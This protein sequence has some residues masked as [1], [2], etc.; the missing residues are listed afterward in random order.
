MKR[1]ALLPAL[2]RLRILVVGDLMLDRYWMGDA[3]RLSPEAPVPVV[4][5]RETR[6]LL[7][8]AGNVALNLAAIGVKQIGLLGVVGRDPA[9]E[10]LRRL[11]EERGIAA[12]L[13]EDASRPTVTKVRIISR[14][15]QVTRVDFEEVF[16]AEASAAVAARYVEV[17]GDYDA[18]IFSDYAKGA[19][20]SI[21]EMLAQPNGPALKLV[22]P[23]A[24]D[25]GRYRGATWITPNWSEFLAAGGR[26]GGES[27]VETSAR[28]LL[29]KAGI[30]RMLLTRG[31]KGVSVLGEDVRADFPADVSKVHDVTGAGDTVIAVFA[32]CLATGMAAAEA[33]QL[34]NRAAG[35]VVGR[36]GAAQVSA[37]EL[38]RLYVG[39]HT[40]D[41]T[42]TLE[43][44]GEIFEAIAAARRAGERIVF[45][46]GCFD[47]LHYGHVTLLQTCRR[48]GDRLVVGLNSDASVRRLKGAPRPVND[49]ASRAGVLLAL[50]A[51]DWVIP[52]GADGDDT[53]R[54]LIRALLPDVLVKGGDYTL[55]DI[56]GAKE[57]MES[58]G[59]VEIVPLV[60]GLS[61][62]NLLAKGHHS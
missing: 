56:V 49:F 24:R 12:H 61:T 21:A 39:Q 51:V 46:N 37:E 7:G 4:K 54:E 57:V 31:E 16:S 23:K 14:E 28:E 6:D 17:S 3:Q 11:I 42:P 47:V 13:V 27:E 34:A 25:F 33:A 9:G 19:L 53:P 26:E 40:S 59:K 5:V 30:G 2:A 62:T 44:M 45:T 58:G 48:F 10:V 20:I 55:E 22:D 29:R 15:Q 52:F 35:V 32:A 41:E 43:G 38:A 60:E 8:G 50:E 18:V 36:L 1:S